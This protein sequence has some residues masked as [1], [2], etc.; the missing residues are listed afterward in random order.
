MVLVEAYFEKQ[1]PSHSVD[2]IS[3]VIDPIM[4]YMEFTQ[5]LLEARGIRPQTMSS[6][7]INVYETYTADGITKLSI[8]LRYSLVNILRIHPIYLCSL[9]FN[10]Q[11]N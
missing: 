2:L 11:K 10:A 7:V 1:G 3:R 9:F 5:A 8:I 6:D 4:V